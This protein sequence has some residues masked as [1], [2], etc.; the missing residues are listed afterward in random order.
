MLDAAL[1]KRASAAANAV[2]PATPGSTGVPSTFATPVPKGATISRTQ[3]VTLDTATGASAPA[4]VPEIPKG[5]PW[6]K[7]EV[8]AKASTPGGRTAKV[9]FVGD[10]DGLT[11]QFGDGSNVTCRLD[12]TDAPEVAHKAYTRKDGKSVNASP[13]QV[14]GRESQKSLEAMVL[15]KEVTIKVT[16]VEG[17]RTFCEVEIQGKNVELSQIEGGM[18][19]VYDRYVSAQNKDGFKAAETKARQQRKG[20]WGELNPVNPETFRRQFN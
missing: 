4:K 3:A 14:F 11:G 20:L 2:V 5:L 1:D 18:A 19:W 16:K 15:N 12:Q 9:T 8:V 17:S 6:G 7:P 10:G 13:D